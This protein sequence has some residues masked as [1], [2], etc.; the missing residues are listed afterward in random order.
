MTQPID[1]V[2]TDEQSFNVVDPIDSAPPGSD[3]GAYVEESVDQLTMGQQVHTVTF[4]T[5]KESSDY[6][7]D[8]LVVQNTVDDPP[9]V[10]TADMITRFDQNGFD[11]LLNA[12]PDTGNYYLKWK[13]RIPTA[14]QSGITITAST[15]QTAGG[16]VKRVSTVTQ[17][18]ITSSVSSPTEL[19][20]ITLGLADGSIQS[21]K[22]ADTFVTGPVL[23]PDGA[24][25]VT[26]KQIDGNNNTVTNIGLS[27]LTGSGIIA[28]GLTD[29]NSD[30]MLIW[31][32]G[33]KNFRF[34]GSPS[35]R[36]VSTTVHI[37]VRTDGKAG[38][39]TAEDPLDGSTAIKF[40]TIL[41]GLGSNSHIVLQGGP[42]A[43]FLTDGD[44]TTGTGF[45]VKDG[46]WVSGGGATLKLNSLAHG[47]VGGGIFVNQ[48][49][50]HRVLIEDLVLDGN[51]A[52]LINNLTATTPIINLFLNGSYITVRNVR[53]TNAYGHTNECFP[54]TLSSGDSSVTESAQYN[55]FI[56]C[57]VDTTHGD[58][59]NA[60]CI[61]GV[62]E[63]QAPGHHYPINYSGCVRCTVNG[64]MNQ[65]F[66][67]AWTQNCKFLDCTA[68]LTG[69]NPSLGFGMYTDTGFNN[70]LTVA[71]CYFE[72]TGGRGIMFNGNASP[73]T[74]NYV[75][76][77]N[78]TVKVSSPGG[79]GI[80][81]NAQIHSHATIM[82]NEVWS[83]PGGSNEQ[84]AIEVYGN[85]MDHI[86]VVHNTI[87]T[88]AH[89]INATQG[90][91][92]LN[93]E[94]NIIDEVVPNGITLGTPNIPGQGTNRVIQRNTLAVTSGNGIIITDATPTGVVIRNNKVYGVSGTT[95]GI[96]FG[97]SGGHF[98][99]DN[100]LDV[101]NPTATLGAAN[102]YHSNFKVDGSFAIAD[103]PGGS[104][105]GTS[106]V[107]GQ[108]SNGATALTVK[109]FTD[110]A[111]TGYLLKVVKADGTLLGS[112]D[113]NAVVNGH[114]LVS[115]GN[116]T[117]NNDISQVILSGDGGYFSF[118]GNSG[119]R[120]T[121]DDDNL[122]SDVT[123]FLPDVTNGTLITTSNLPD[124]NSLADVTFMNGKN[125]SFDTGTGTKIGT[126][127]GQKFAFWNAS[128]AAQQVLATGAG[129][130][131]DNVITFLQS[132]G[133]CRQS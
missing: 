113:V 96:Y 92:H 13:V 118:I 31:D 33:N 133:L 4:A 67:P 40:D 53:G 12:K 43:T 7:W 26:N 34:M 100:I 19:P 46:W 52:G 132:I 29:P 55:W 89:G 18:G 62:N 6:L 30:Q 27:S 25:V 41:R 131:V 64:N 65:A 130:T 35:A 24:Q 23:T 72:T 36:G 81:L 76:I 129:H 104:F 94:S 63:D 120:Q 78:N 5:A 108:P 127:T 56:D 60:F 10:I 11:V 69:T 58:Y 21:S 106:G 48:G 109:R 17:D 123:Y 70:N 71:G 59:V 107:Y 111:P 1:T 50:I 54:M 57:S 97:G 86:N 28:Q 93:I 8:Q 115:A 121:I 119:F 32:N 74:N 110:T 51:W 117:L 77:I 103:T 124:I 122:T 42:S 116:V 98:I 14:I 9:L 91:S 99:T 101:S 82:G 22:L 3:I 66:S 128:P 114:T 49:S 38:T 88:G 47:G 105:S 87:H 125:I 90:I 61:F 79:G 45:F 15:A 84:S 44:S 39:G 68:V 75:S 20:T 2:V 126:A 112:I 73:W 16:T 80:S 102:F 85:S 37:A 83:G 95:T